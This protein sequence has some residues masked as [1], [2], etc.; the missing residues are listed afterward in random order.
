[1]TAQIPQVQALSGSELYEQDFNLWIQTTADLLKQK[2]FTQLD[3][4][5]LIE[6][7]ESMGR[8]HRRAMESNLEVVLSHL[9][10]YQYQ[11]KR[12]SRSWLMTLRE[13]RKRLNNSL[14]DNP[15]LKPY[16]LGILAVCYQEAREMAKLET[17]LDITTFPEELPFTPTQI[18]DTEFFADA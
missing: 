9:L 13:H 18:L 8:N 14:E 11:P 5:N 2:D 7:I 4:D 15:S 16:F 12:R 17:G 3:L 10:K 1:M 6:E